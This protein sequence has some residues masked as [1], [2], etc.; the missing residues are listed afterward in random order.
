VAVNGQLPLVL[1]VSGLC[2]TCSLPGVAWGI[3]EDGGGG[4]WITTPP[5]GPCPGGT[6]QITGTD[7][8]DSLTVTY[9]APSTAGTYHVRSQAILAGVASAVSTVTVTP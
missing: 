6:I 1:T 4:N 2:G 5:A 3:D 8:G 9:F 7:V